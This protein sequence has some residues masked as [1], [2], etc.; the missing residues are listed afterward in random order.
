MQDPADL[1]SPGADAVRRRVVLLSMPFARLCM[2]SIGLAL[3]QAA[4]VPLG[5]PSTVRYFGLSFA[6]RIGARLYSEVTTR[7][8]EGD[9]VGEWLF[10]E[11]LFGASAPAAEG[12]EREVLSR[13]PAELI[14]PIRR[15]RRL[16]VEPFLEHCCAELCAERPAFV[17]LTSL[18]QQHVPSLALARRL[19]ALSPSTFVVLGGANCESVMGAETVR[20]F[21]FV[22]AVVSGEADRVFPELVRRVL[23]AEPCD[24]L[25][26]VFTARSIVP[27]GSNAGLPNAPAPQD[28]D[29]LAAPVF[30]DFFSSYEQ[31]RSDDA[32][33]DGSA[34]LAGLDR[35]DPP[36]LLME[37]SRGCWWG[38]K[39]HCSFC[40]MS[41]GLLA[42]RSKSAHRALDELVELVRRHPGVGVR[43]VDNTLDPRRLR[44]LVPALAARPIEA[45]IFYE[46][47][48]GLGKEH[49]QLLCSAGITRIQVG[50]ESFS[51]DVL[52]LMHKGTRG[53][54]N[55]ALLKWCA[56]LGIAPTWLLLW[57]IPGEPPED[58]ARM[59]ALVPRLAHLPPPARGMRMRLERFSPSFEQRDAIGLVGVEPRPGYRHVYPLARDVLFNLAYYFDYGYGD[60]RDVA[61]YTAPLARAVEDWKLAYPRAQLVMNDEGDALRVIDT[62]PAARSREHRLTGLAR[63][64]LRACDGVTRTDALLA[65]A[66]HHVGAPVSSAQLE[67]EL[68]ALADAALVITEHDRHLAL[69]VDPFERLRL[70][71]LR[72]GRAVGK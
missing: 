12:F 46:I 6:A 40:G 55:I 45:E 32:G 70:R 19:K 64:L 36:L 38:Q 3:L 52:A 2:P 44:D 18:F 72:A 67:L 49:L 68:G 48:A 29:A 10:A 43:M 27:G 4:L 47:K 41:P 56:E 25:Q 60:G 7:G 37:T 1:G 5:I 58:Y 15:V 17:G 16:E 14:E 35:L 66:A 71:R 63:V 39:Q 31:L 50:I 53:L 28:L 69:P 11:A 23:A 26:G 54:D 51:D 9:L 34:G 22:D 42:F 61:A 13:Y 8:G 59:A 62:R 65:L 21:P 33:L 24:E 20:Q 57:G 30:G